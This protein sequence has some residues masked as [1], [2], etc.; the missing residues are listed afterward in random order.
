[1]KNFDY[2]IGIDVSKLTLDV[3]VLLLQTGK[4]ELIDYQ[5]IDNNEK[6]VVSYLEKVFKGQCFPENTL[7][8]FEDTGIYSMPLAYILS[9]QQLNYWQVPA[10]EIKRSKGICRGKSDKTDSK[11]IALY[12]FSHL[13]KLRLSTVSDAV[14]Q[15]LRLLFSEREKIIKSLGA[16][17]RTSENKDF[18]SKEVF[19]S[20]ENINKDIV[21]QLDNSLKKVEEKLMDIIQEDEKI[22]QEFELINSICGVGRY[23]ALYLI[24]CTKGFSC[25]EN[26]RQLACYAGVAPF[27][28]SSG[29]S[30]RGKTR[31]SSLADMKLK[32]LLNMCA[33]VA[34]R[35]DKELRG[36]YERKLAEGKPKML[37]INNV[38]CKLLARIFA[39]INRN[40]PFVNTWKFAG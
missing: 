37:V 38:R 11:G 30:V 26:W 5:V 20:V 34:I 21:T 32:S 2:F 23:T 36:Y 22:T 7:F 28:Y 35:R 9:D 25:F 17:K 15:K 33:L 8:C 16:F 13:Y 3:T 4:E 1:M 24:I 31:V 39:V 18:C 27:E 12:A 29:T 19:Q 40:S 6:R 10:L 14:I